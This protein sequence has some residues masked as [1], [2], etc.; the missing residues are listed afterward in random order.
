MLC[1]ECPHCK[2]LI[3]KYVVSSTSYFNF[4][5]H[6]GIMKKFLAHVSTDIDTLVSLPDF[7]NK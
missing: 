2:I 6:G 3:C 4:F 7:L 5:A 1:H